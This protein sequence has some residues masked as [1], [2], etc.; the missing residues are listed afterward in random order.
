[1]TDESQSGQTN[2][3]SDPQFRQALNESARLLSANRPGEA[4]RILETLLKDHPHNPDIAINLGGALILQRKWNRAVT[5]LESAVKQH[6]DNVMLW[7]NLGAAYLGRLET[8]GPK[9]QERAISAYERAV[10]LDPNAPNVHYHLGLIHKERG[11]L[12]RAYAHFQRASEVN[13]A[14][15]DARYWIDRLGEMLAEQVRQRNQD[16]E[17]EEGNAA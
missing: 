14:D 10:Q 11:S 2:R 13:P 4:V 7:S 15:R 8:A 17:D 16:P 3:S 12:E 1:M 5:V 6:P 9:Q